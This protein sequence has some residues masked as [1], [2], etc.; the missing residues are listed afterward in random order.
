VRF[1]HPRV[2]IAVAIAGTVQLVLP[3]PVHAQTGAGRMESHDSARTSFNLWG[4][5]IALA[6]RV[7]PGLDNRSY[8][9]GYLAQPLMMAHGGVLV[10]HL[11]GVRTLYVEVVTLRR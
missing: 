5:A 6:T 9:E 3:L 4:Q 1:H 10:C 7:D 8:T 2:A 11:S